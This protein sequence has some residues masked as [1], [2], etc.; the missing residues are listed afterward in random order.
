M[1]WGACTAHAHLGER[2]LEPEEPQP[3][4]VYVGRCPGDE[5]GRRLEQAWDQPWQEDCELLEAPVHLLITDAELH[6]TITAWRQGL[7]SIEN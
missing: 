2:V 6:A 1:T 3:D 7:R 4:L 5:L